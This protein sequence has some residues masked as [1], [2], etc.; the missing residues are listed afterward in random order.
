MPFVELFATLDKRL[1]RNGSLFRF[2]QKPSKRNIEWSTNNLLEMEKYYQL[3]TSDDFCYPENYLKM[4]NT[5]V[6]P[7]EAARRITEHFKL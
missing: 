7:I 1:E 3:N 2:A 6:S 5:E 4:D